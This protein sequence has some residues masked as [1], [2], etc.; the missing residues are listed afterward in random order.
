MSFSAKRGSPGYVK[1]PII[2]EAAFIG[3]MKN[4]LFPFRNRFPTSWL[5]HVNDSYIEDFELLSSQLDYSL[6]EDWTKSFPMGTEY[7]EIQ[8][9]SLETLTKC[10]VNLQAKITDIKESQSFTNLISKHSESKRLTSFKI[11]VGS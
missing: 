1:A 8:S 11:E 10:V 5:K 2:T 4:F 7:D 6:H 9:R 3:G